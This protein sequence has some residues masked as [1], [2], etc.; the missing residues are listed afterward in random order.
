LIAQTYK[1]EKIM[2][3]LYWCSI[4]LQRL[5]RLDE[6][7]RSRQTLLNAEERGDIPYAER[8]ARGTTLAR[9]WRIDQLPAI[10]E[11]F[12]FLKKP[13]EQKIIN[14]YTPQS[15]SLKTT[16]SY[17][18]ARMLALHGMKTLIIGLDVQ[19]SITQLVL[20]PNVVESL[21]SVEL[22]SL[23]GLYHYFYDDLAIESVIQSTSLPTL[24]IIPET[25]ELNRLEKQL[26]SEQSI[27]C[28]NET[29][30]PELTAYDVIIFDSGSAWSKTVENALIA[31]RTILLPISCEFPAYQALVTHLDMI[32]EFK[33]ENAIDWDQFM[34][35][36]TLLEK[37][38]AS[39]QIYAAYLSGYPN[40]VLPL[41]I[42]RDIK[43]DEANQTRQT[44]FEYDAAA[45]ITE[46]YY[47]FIT[48]FWNRI[49]VSF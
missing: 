1:K 2:E 15:R 34:W 39:Q 35:V 27:Q 5:F 37:T 7:M 40:Y 45:G 25:P 43:G 3:Q 11:K 4:D 19:S 31:A 33:E 42:R 29:L 12:G 14:V 44:I 6:R 32:T 46:D 10:G 23:P 41:P 20:G 9:R 38:N 28:F 8:Y 21:D 13:N 18:L 49:R 17:T 22:Y 24:D 26:W 48:Q 36:P 47:E 30:I 16:L